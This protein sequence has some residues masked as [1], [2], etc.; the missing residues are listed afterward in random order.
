MVFW[1]HRELLKVQS[2][3]THGE[4]QV[5]K[6]LLLSESLSPK[7]RS[8]GKDDFFKP[9]KQ[10]PRG[11]S[12]QVPQRNVILQQP[13]KQM[14]WRKSCVFRLKVKQGDWRKSEDKMLH[15]LTSSL[16]S[17]VNSCQTQLQKISI[18]SCN[19]SKQIIAWNLFS[20]WG[21]SLSSVKTH[22]ATLRGFWLF[23]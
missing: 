16:A 19:R 10:S 8:P 14:K 11:E 9:L 17:W 5:S 20:G 6:S 4:Q 7:G 12:L 1:L 3:P 23:F 15:L 2:I 22:M 21:I 13:K 18:L